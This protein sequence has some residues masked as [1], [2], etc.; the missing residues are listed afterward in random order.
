MH[1]AGLCPRP[2]HH[3]TMARSCR[4]KLSLLRLVPLLALVAGSGPS[5]TRSGSRAA[6]AVPQTRIPRVEALPAAPRGWH[7]IDWAG[8]AA[9]L[10]RW[11]YGDPDTVGSTTFLNITWESAWCVATLTPPG[12]RP[13]DHPGS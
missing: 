11:V 3:D 13:C 8:K 2:H 4:A 9:S 6:H 5:S 1:G 12:S 10:Y 7:V